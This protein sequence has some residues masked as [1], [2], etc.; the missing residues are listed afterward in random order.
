VIGGV[1]AW[2]LWGAKSTPQSSAFISTPQFL[3]WLL[4]LCAQ[5][6][7]WVLA[8]AFVIVTVRRRWNELRDAQALSSVRIAEIA[9]SALLLLALARVFSFSGQTAF[10]GLVS[11]SFKHVPQGGAWPLWRHTTKVPV[12]VVI[13]LI[14]GLVALVGIWLIGFAFERLGQT[15]QTTAHDIERFLSLRTDLSALLAIVGTIIGL[16]TLATGALR[17]AVLAANNEPFFKQHPGMKL[18][19]AQEYVLA[20]GLFFTGLLAIAFAPSLLAMRAAGARLRDRAYPLPE[21]TDSSF[22]AVNDKR[23]ALDELLQVNL[24]ATATFKAGV[25][26]LAPLAGSVVTLLLP[27]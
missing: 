26:I 5:A 14:V 17:Q 7:F 15:K 9:V 24:S 12:L 21:P 1:F 10:F 2:V 19:F 11:T 6:T 16:G 13:A 23:K 25:A 18:E 22:G 4:M 20:Y 27:K 3:L 8:L